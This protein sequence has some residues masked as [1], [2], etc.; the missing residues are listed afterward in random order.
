[1]FVNLPLDSLSLKWKS[2]FCKHVNFFRLK[3]S[4]YY[5]NM[6][7]PPIYIAFS[8]MVYAMSLY[9][10]QLW[11]RKLL[12]HHKFTG[13]ACFCVSNYKCNGSE[14]AAN[15]LELF[16]HRQVASFCFRWYKV[17]NLRN[18]TWR[19]SQSTANIH[20]FNVQSSPSN[21]TRMCTA[22]K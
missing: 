17:I 13:K 21:S 16:A 4:C 8:T 10:E 2:L 20:Y 11:W 15:V 19:T 12:D 6:T 7:V 5:A 14:L 22:L 9:M 1:M 3:A 18:A